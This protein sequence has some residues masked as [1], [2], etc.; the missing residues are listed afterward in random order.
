MQQ[1]GHLCPLTLRHSGSETLR[2]HLEN[3]AIDKVQ[4]VFPSCPLLSDLTTR[5]PYARLTM[6]VTCPA[7]VMNFVLDV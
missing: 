1:I 7:N 2:R 6:R 3:W 4:S 5:V